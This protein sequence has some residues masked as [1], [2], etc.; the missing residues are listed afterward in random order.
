MANDEAEPAAKT[1]TKKLLRGAR[2][3]ERKFRVTDGS[4]FRLKDFEPGEY[5]LRMK[6]TDKFNN[7]TLSPTA[8]FKVI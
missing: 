2:R 7:A 8:T 5:T 4:S 1:S 6:V 3:L